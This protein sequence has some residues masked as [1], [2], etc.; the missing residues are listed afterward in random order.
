M[1]SQQEI[2]QVLQQFNQKHQSE[3][4]RIVGIFGSY[5]RNTADTFSD[6]DLTYKIDH[7]RFYKDNAFAKLAAIETFKQELEKKFK[8]KVDLIP[9]NTKN[10]LIQESLREEQIAL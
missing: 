8:T 10:P 1:K 7:E 6:V 5:A 3:G 4:F 9:A 2:I